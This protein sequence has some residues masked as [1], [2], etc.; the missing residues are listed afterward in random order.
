MVVQL[1][2]FFKLL[3]SFRLEAGSTAGR[4][5]QPGGNSWLRSTGSVL[6]DILA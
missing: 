1:F 6:C 2:S 5:Y 3:K 4:S